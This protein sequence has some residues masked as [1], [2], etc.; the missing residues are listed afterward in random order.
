MPT[1]IPTLI[2]DTFRAWILVVLPP[3]PQSLQRR[4]GLLAE[5]QELVY[6]QLL[7]DRLFV[8]MVAMY[9]LFIVWEYDIHTHAHAQDRLCYVSCCCV[10]SVDVARAD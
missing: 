6:R 1:L 4:H 2:P 7:L 3:L 10:L 8:P 5:G 9:N